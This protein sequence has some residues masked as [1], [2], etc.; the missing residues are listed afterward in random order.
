MGKHLTF[1]DRLEIQAGLDLGRSINDIANGLG[2][3]RSVV[4]RE[5]DKRK[6][7]KKAKGNDCIH[8]NEC[9]FPDACGK[10]K[11]L[12][13]IR[14][15]RCKECI[16]GCSRYQK[17]ECERIIYTP[18]YLCNGCR[19]EG[20]PY[21]Q[22][23]YNAKKAQAAYEHT[24]SDSR[25]GISLTEAEL[26]HLNSIV[27]DPVK[28]GQ[29]I[30]VVCEGSRDDMEVSGRTIYRYINAGLLSAGPLD[31]SRTVQRKTFRKKSGAELK[32]DRSCHIGRTYD[33]LGEFRTKNP[34]AAEVEIDSVIGRKGGKAILTVFFKNCGLQ[35]MFLRDRNTAKT[36]SEIFVGLR[37]I[38]GDEIYSSMFEIV[39]TDRGSEFTDPK[40]IEY[41]SWEEGDE[42]LCHVFYCDPMNSNQKAEC[43]RNHEFIRNVLPKGTSFDNLTQDDVN[44]MMNHINSY[45]RPKRGFLTPIDLFVQIYSQ[46][47][48][49]LLGLER[50]EL[51]DIV[52]TPALLKK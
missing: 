27:A 29:S 12:S 39:I 9:K 46:E 48:A 17:Q 3:H 32:V 6:L 24:L 28:K 13:P 18:P 43:E 4:T 47:I 14:C 5:I 11:H 2:R 10:C 15:G 33:D 38:L 8:R 41:G 44:L 35:L 31:L 52:L 36:V 16:E 30:A 51:S 34:D 26:I 37:E 7:V 50:I 22:Y 19:K 1:D 49:D 23:Y 40:K 42:V 45:P 21:E 20:C 25:K